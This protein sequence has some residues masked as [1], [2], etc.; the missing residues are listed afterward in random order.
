MRFGL[1]LSGGALRGVAHIGV[2]KA[3]WEHKLYPSWISGTSAG[4]IVAALYACGYSPSQMEAIAYKLNRQIFDAD[5][6]GV[7]VAL[8]QWIL[9]GNMHLDGIIK[10]N[11]IEM[12]IK[13]LT[14]GA[15]MKDAEIPLGITAVNINNGQNIIFLSRKSSHRA[16]EHNHLV[17][18]NV[19][20]YE[21]VRASISIPVLFK[22]KMIYNM[23]L[24]D[25]GVSDN[26]PITALKL[27][28]ADIC[29]GVNLGYC[30]QMRREVDNILEIGNQTIDIMAYHITR[31]KSG[32]ADLIIN[33]H[34][35]DIGMTEFDKIPYCISKGY[36][37]VK[38][39]IDLIKKTIN[40]YTSTPPF[41]KNLR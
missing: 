41:Y 40:S 27:M 35:Y 28:G 12:L 2:L 23:R 3:L 26:L 8:I 34:I 38:E 21:A 5:C 25:G 20:I 24:V 6:A 16:V 7:F 18:E 10:G 31:L 19:P 4:S 30:G 36:N 1:A 13:S 33:P 22:P 32:Q 39:N 37:C 14:K 15:M 17:I 9:T 11:R 29:L